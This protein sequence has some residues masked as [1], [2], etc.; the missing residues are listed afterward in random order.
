[1]FRYVS[2][3]SSQGLYDST[4]SASSVWPGHGGEAGRGRLSRRGSPG[5]VSGAASTVLVVNDS[6]DS[7]ELMSLL[8]SRAGYSVL[9]AFDGQEG[10]EVASRERPRLV[11]SDVSMPRA[12]GIELCR[13]MR[14][15]E[16]LR[17]TPVLLVSAIR[18]DS[19]SVVEGLKA[20]ADD[21]LE[22]PYDPALL[23]AKVAQLVEREEAEEALRESELRLHTVIENLAEGLIIS[24]PGGRLLYWNRAGLEMHGFSDLEE[25]LRR[26]PEF[27][28]IYELST[29]DGRVLGLEEWPMPR[30][31][32]GERLRNFEVRVRHKESGW[33]RIF[34]YGGSTVRQPGG[35]TLAFLTIRD[36]TERKQAE[37]QIR[38]LNETLEGR[39][40]ERTAQLEA[41]NEELEA[42]SYSVSHDLRAPLRHIDGFTRALL[43]DHSDELS[44]EGKG[45]LREVR[46]A[47]RE[48]ARLIEDILQLARVTRSEM[49]REVVSLSEL[50]GEAVAELRKGDAGGDVV[51]RIE[52]GLLARGDRRLLQIML[53]NLLGNAWKFTS[54]RAGAEI[55]FG[56]EERGG[57]TVY[58][59]RDNGAGFDMAYAHKLFVPFQRLHSVEEFEGTGVGLATV[60]RVVNRHRGRVWAEGMPGRGAIFYFTIPAFERAKPDGQGEPAGEDRV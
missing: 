48:M 26:L 18:K 8:L 56:R 14:G 49:R 3:L 13:L 38:Q 20:G 54:K 59:V 27:E 30:A 9:T 41:A 29:T 33:E 43:E 16:G 1:M 19:E 15:H 44:E 57:E 10:F 50:A 22:A 6:P 32:R 39:V 23:L 17:D 24:E 4:V 12:D 55:V 45:Y 36:I 37:E 28:K 5:R 58:Y 42:F 53:V 60:R 40:R 21:Y 51:V 7:L 11:V 46:D 25:G 52:E 31:L 34:S 2:C 47:S 35:E